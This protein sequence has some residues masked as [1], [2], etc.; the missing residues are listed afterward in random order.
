MLFILS[1]ELNAESCTLYGTFVPASGMSLILSC[2]IS[3]VAYV[4]GS[5]GLA[6]I[7]LTAII[8]LLSCFEN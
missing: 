2:S 8:R 1:Y 4:S 6:L 7:N 5:A 3:V